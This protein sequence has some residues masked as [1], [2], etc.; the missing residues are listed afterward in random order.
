MQN[1][2]GY[3]TEGDRKAYYETYENTKKSND[4]YI[5]DIREENNTL[6][7]ELAAIQRELS[8]KGGI[9]AAESEVNDELKKV[10]SWAIKF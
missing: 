10:L 3:E 6:R 2:N 8:V 5:K 9:S 4:A 7:K 1:I